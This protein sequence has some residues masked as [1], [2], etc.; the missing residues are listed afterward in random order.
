MNASDWSEEL[1]GRLSA[2][3]EAGLERRLRVSSGH[4]VRLQVDGRRVVSFASNDYLGLSGDARVLE[5]ARQALAEHGAG[6]TASRLLAGNRPPHV[7]LEKDLAD[8]KQSAAAL[9]F[10]TGYQTALGTLTALAGAV[11]AGGAPAACA[12][13]LDRLAHAC[14]LDGARLATARV[15]TFRHNDVADLRRL[16]AAESEGE[17]Q[18]AHSPTTTNGLSVPERQTAPGRPAGRVLVVVESLYSMDGDLAPLAEIYAAARLRLSLSALHT[19]EDIVA[20][21]R[22][23]GRE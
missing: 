4:G 23:L 5:A 18:T 22:S 13:V 19:E 1:R 8:F 3:R 11:A 14:L 6:A 20:L 10:A 2:W 9:V 16:L 12:I 7:L 17:G 15:R 21:T